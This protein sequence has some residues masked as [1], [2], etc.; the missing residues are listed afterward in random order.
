MNTYLDLGICKELED[1]SIKTLPEKCSFKAVNSKGEIV[2]VYINGI[3][4][5]PV[6][7]VLS[8]SNHSISIKNCSNLM[9]NQFN[10]FSFLSLFSNEQL[11][12][13]TAHS[14]ANSCKHEKFRK[15]LNLMEYIDEKFD[16][17]DLYPS[18]DCFLDGRILSVDSS[19]RGYG[20]AG[21][22]TEKSLEFA[23][24]KNIPLMSVLCSSHYSARV[25]EKL[26]F[27]NVYTLNFVDYFVDGVNP[28]L[29]KEPHKSVRILVKEI[30]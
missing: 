19:Y 20:I 27:K 8:Q 29:P 10:L 2:G 18:I 25:C 9:N 21:R 7:F 6:S 28:I 1:Y 5:R 3:V 16:I 13:E 14:Y 26:N 12:G 30:V 24:E 4:K 22:L 11:P 15:I 17:F 23:K